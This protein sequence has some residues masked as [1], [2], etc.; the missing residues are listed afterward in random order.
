M[1]RGREGMA[2]RERERRR[3]QRQEA[4]HLRR[5]SIAAE[6]GG[7]DPQDEALLMEEF[8]LSSERHAAGLITD[9]A[10][11]LERHRIFTELGIET[12]DP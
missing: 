8:R 11:T 1:A 2:K 3:Q 12:E 5:E 6:A 9:E 10:F 7:P 4:K